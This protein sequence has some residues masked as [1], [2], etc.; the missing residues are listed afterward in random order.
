MY[1]A[2]AL[3]RLI[4]W[5]RIPCLPIE[6]YNDEFLLRIGS[7]LEKPIKVDRNTSMVSRGHY[8]RICIE[9]NMEKPLVAKFKLRRRVRPVEYEGLHLVCFSCGRYGHDAEKCLVRGGSGGAGNLAGK[10]HANDPID[11]DKDKG[12]AIPNNPMIVNDYG[13]WMLVKKD[14]RNFKKVFNKVLVNKESSKEKFSAKEKG[15]KPL[16][17]RSNQYAALEINEPAPVEPMQLPPSNTIDTGS[18]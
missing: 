14:K 11:L 17:D 6:Y 9:I 2:N 16:T 7:L 18:F 12:R 3:E 5:A 1:A 13:D 4:V 15:A 8:A 10:A